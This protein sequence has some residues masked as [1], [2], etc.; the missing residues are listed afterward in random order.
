MKSDAGHN[1]FTVFALGVHEGDRIN[2][3]HGAEIGKV[4]GHCCSPDI[5]GNS[6]V[7]FQFTGPHTDDLFVHPHA[8][9]HL[10]VPV[11]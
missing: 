4:P 10:P 9:R 11:A 3:L 1:V 7:I 2:D 8:D 5:Y 6:I